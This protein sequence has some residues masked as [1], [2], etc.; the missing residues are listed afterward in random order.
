MKTYYYKHEEPYLMH[1]GVKG[2]KWG[3]RRY[4]NADGTL[5]AKGKER[6]KIFDD[7]AK[8][9][10]KFAR[11]AHRNATDPSVYKV[12]RNNSMTPADVS[13]MRS[14]SS[15]Q[16]KY[17]RALAQQYRNTSVNDLA[18]KKAVKAAKKF[19]KKGWFDDADYADFEWNGTSYN[20][21]F[22]LQVPGTKGYVDPDMR[23]R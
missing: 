15:H 3:V 2:M 19:V 14:A 17:Y 23:T 22:S 18:N 9:A 16:E 21:L 4:Q 5:T 1:Y 13:R 7:A 10:D 20:T 6:Q 8:K 11:W 12:T